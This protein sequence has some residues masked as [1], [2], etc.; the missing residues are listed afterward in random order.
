M[1]GRLSR[2]ILFVDDMA[3]MK[4]F[5]VDVVGLTEV[6][7]GDEMFVSLDSG[8]AQL[9][10][11]QIPPEYQGNDGSERADCAVKFVF[12]SDD[13]DSDREALVARGVRMREINRWGEIELC[14]GI[15]PEGN[16]FQLSNR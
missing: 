4:S 3:K 1:I 9:S 7:G 8:G 2:V 14:D 16:I 11:H 15:D 13:V 5:Y 10:L 6:P 12:H